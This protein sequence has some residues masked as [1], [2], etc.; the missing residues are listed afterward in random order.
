MSH[1]RDSSRTPSDPSQPYVLVG[2][3]HVP[4]LDGIRGLAVAL[5][6]MRHFLGQNWF[7]LDW[8]RSPVGGSLDYYVYNLARLGSNGVDMF[9]VLSGFLITGILLDTKEGPGYFKNFYMRRT[10][11]IFPLYYLALAISF[12]VWP[13][14]AGSHPSWTLGDAGQYKTWYWLY[15]ANILFAVKQGYIGLAHFWSL[16][17]EE[18][19]YLFWPLLVLILARKQLLWA[20]AACFVVAITTRFLCGWYN[21]NTLVAYVLTPGRVDALAVG[22]AI[23]AVARGPNGLAGIKKFGFPVLITSF[24]VLVILVATTFGS[25]RSHLVNIL[26]GSL[27]ALLFGAVLLIAV[28]QPR[29]AILPRVFCSRPLA[30]LGKFS[31]CLYVCH[32]FVQEFVEWHWNSSWIPT[33]G[34]SRIPDRLVFACVCAALSLLVSWISWHAFE[35]HWLLLKKYF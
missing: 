20:C 3:S 6:M 35:K 23:A 19:F 15:A 28:T 31:Y 22:A 10:L 24:L 8:E 1:T 34:S 21:L 5:V 25:G 9:F 13:S 32:P 16:A 29:G 18:Q 4:P 17:V 27:A 33:L 14:V 11:R 7:G 26:G 12:F 2:R 30:V